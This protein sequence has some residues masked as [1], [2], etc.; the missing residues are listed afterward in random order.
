MSLQKTLQWLGI[1]SPATHAEQLTATLGGTLSLTLV[2]F[3]SYLMLDAQGTLAVVPSMGATAVLLFA[4]PHGPL[5]QPWALFAGH[6]L[7][8]VIG[9]S[10]ALW[11]PNTALAAGLAVGLAI[12]AMHVCR[13]IHPPG[14][15]TA[16]A[17]VIG[18]DAVSQLGYLFIL[19]PI[20]L[21][22]VLIFSVALMFNNLF[23]WRRYP[24]AAM[25]YKPSNRLTLPLRPEHFEKALQEMD[26][27][28][29]VSTTQLQEIYEQAESIRQQDVLAAFEFEA[30]GVY[31]NN[32]PGADWAIR[33]IIDYASH[34]DPHK[35]LI[36]YRVLDGA[37]KNST[38][39]CSRSEF[40]SWAQQKLQ[41]AKP[42]GS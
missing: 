4:V 36:I 27:V 9:V 1:Q 18:G 28:V 29:D 5:S 37:Q 11:V 34:P 2:S 15:A 38:G 14:G 41:P 42:A 21:N 16:L 6:L 33:K 20:L 12:G 30:G 7:S 26:S 22:C 32:R 25:H 17:A 3:I 8:A 40:A 10:C 13:C 24:M 31:S 39:S 35:A 19:T 23:A